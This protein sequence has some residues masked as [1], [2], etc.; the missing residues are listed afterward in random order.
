MNA[1]DNF[2]NDWVFDVSEPRNFSTKVEDSDFLIKYLETEGYS[3]RS[4]IEPGYFYCV[5]SKD[6]LEVSADSRSKVRPRTIQEAVCLAA[7]KVHLPEN[8]QRSWNKVYRA[9]NLPH[10]VIEL[11]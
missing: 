10:L 9:L 3:V 11:S 6:N 1:L 2:I 4:S 8:D 5:I 7:L